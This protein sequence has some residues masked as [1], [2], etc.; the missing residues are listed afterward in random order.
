MVCMAS[1]LVGTAVSTL[2]HRGRPFMSGGST[3]WPVSL[4]TRVV[5]LITINFKDQIRNPGKTTGTLYCCLIV[6]V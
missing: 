6:V 1:R 5:H 4:F 2:L 3:R